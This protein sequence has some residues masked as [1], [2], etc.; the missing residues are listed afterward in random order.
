MLAAGS[1]RTGAIDGISAAGAAPD[2][3]AHTPSADAEIL[4]Y[5]APVRSPVVPVSPTG[6]PTPAVV[7]RAVLERLDV[8]VTVVDAA[9]G[10]AGGPPVPRNL[11]VGR[12][13]RR[14]QAR[15]R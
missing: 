15:L 1:T 10:P 14:I 11:F 3:L 7:T 9:G 4:V 8:E 12:V 13:R 5:G 6:C 2:L